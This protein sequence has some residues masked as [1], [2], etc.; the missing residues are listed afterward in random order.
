MLPPLP[1]SVG[2]ARRFVVER[3]AS[4]GVSDPD[5]DAAVVVSELVTNAVVHAR[6]EVTVRVLRKG[7]GI[8]RVEVA[9]GSTVLPGPRVATRASRSGRGLTLVDHLSNEWG[10][11]ANGA[12]KIVWFLVGQNG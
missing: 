9:D 2:K 5:D 10:V 7:A 3:L 12:G 1:A 4:L 6:T 8:A 11:E